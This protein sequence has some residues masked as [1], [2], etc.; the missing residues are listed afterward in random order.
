P[1]PRTRRCRVSRGW[2]GPRPPAECLATSRSAPDTH[3]WRADRGGRGRQKPYTRLHAAQA[4]SA[5]LSDPDVVLCCALAA[6]VPGIEGAAGLY[7]HELHLS[8]R[9]RLVFDSLRDDVHLARTQA[10]RPVLEIDPQG[11]FQ[12]DEG[13]VRLGVVVPDEIAV[14]AHELELV[15]VHLRDDFRLP[16]LPE[17]GELLLQVDR[18]T[19]H[20]QELGE[21]GEAGAL[22]GGVGAAGLSVTACHAC[23]AAG[24]SLS[25]CFRKSAS[26]H[27]C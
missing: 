21:A 26:V 10:D 22:A 8:F 16:L 17:E 9:A 1:W 25:M 24:E 4:T 11:P 6:F 18:L 19:A 2:R 15:V 3:G 5:A 23:C 13:L 27:I 14:D 7:Q 20:D 12:Y